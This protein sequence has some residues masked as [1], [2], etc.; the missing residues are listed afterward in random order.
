MGAQKDIPMQGILFVGPLIAKETE[1]ARPIR[2]LSGMRILFKL[3]E[4][5][6]NDLRPCS[7]TG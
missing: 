4:R 3:P 5:Y 6:V 1:R 7:S 2:R